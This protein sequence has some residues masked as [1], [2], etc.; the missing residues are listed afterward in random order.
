MKKLSNQIIFG[1]ILLI[2]GVLF[3]LRSTGIY[4]TGNLLSYVPSLFIILGIYSLI[5]SGFK[6]ISGP[7]TMIIIFTVIQLLVLGVITGSTLSSWWPLVIILIGAGIILNHYQRDKSKVYTRDNIDLMAILGGVQNTIKSS[8]F[9][10]GDLTA[11]LGGVELDL[12]DSQTGLEPAIINVTVLLGGAE[13]RVPD[14][15]D[16]KIN[17]MPVLGGVDD[18]RT[19]LSNSTPKDKPD[20]II[21]GMVALGGLDIY[22]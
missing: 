1:I 9:K 16:L 7:V 12:R 11:V 15:W 5:K 17:V 4:N 22:D 18:S 6:S 14:D 21:N 10:G 2:I 13:I 20:L 19:R 3:L 8:S